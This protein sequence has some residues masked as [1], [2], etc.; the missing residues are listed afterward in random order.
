M[1]ILRRVRDMTVAALND[2]LEKAEDPVKL[3]D[4]FLGATRDEIIQAEQL[5]QQCTTHTIQLKRQWLDAEQQKDRREQQAI[6]ALKAGEEELARMALVDKT[7]HEE[8]AAQYK[9][10]IEQSKQTLI[11]LE[12]RLGELKNEYRTVADKR[13]FYIARMESLRLQQ[14]L[15][16]RH[17]GLQG[18][19]YQ[20]EG[21]FRRLEDRLD[22][23]E[24]E[25]RSLRELRRSASAPIGAGARQQSAIELEL[26]Q[27]KL[28]L[29]KG[30]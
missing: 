10:L 9:Q 28:K 16:D 14:R 7:T 17:S 22:D 25:A 8:R 20:P 27:L 3:I 12:E 1:S 4:R 5:Y 18:G 24:L 23:Q 15:N 21:L 29:A 6:T 19:G 30:G 2:R 26:Q 13:D 11:E